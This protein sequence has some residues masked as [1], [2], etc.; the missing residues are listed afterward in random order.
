M[1]SKFQ[2]PGVNRSAPLAA[3]RKPSRKTLAV[4]QAILDSA[5][6]VFAEKGYHLATLS[7]VSDRLDLHVTALRYHFPTKDAM[8]AEMVNSLARQV[9]T[10]VEDATAITSGSARARIEAATEAYLSVTLAQRTYVRAHGNVI[11]QLPPDHKAQHYDLLEDLNGQWRALI[12]AAD[13]EGA[14]RPG[15]NLSV[16]TQ[17]LLGAMIW[18]QEWFRDGDLSPQELS[19]QIVAMVFDGIGP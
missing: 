18:T 9:L 2:Q 1:T 6:A 11:N 14:L 19:R 8:A 16:A 10:A 3:G 17:V 15:L 4:Q 13:A 5:A 12:Q 7:D